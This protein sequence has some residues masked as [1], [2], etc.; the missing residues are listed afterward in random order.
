MGLE[1]GLHGDTTD[2]GLLQAHDRGK[3]PPMTRIHVCFVPTSVGSTRQ[4]AP[5]ATPSDEI[6]RPI[7]RMRVVEG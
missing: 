6:D 7:L 1:K 3:V 4:K 2:S 5:S